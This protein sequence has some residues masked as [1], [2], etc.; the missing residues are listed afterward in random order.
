MRRMAHA[1]QQRDLDRAV[2]FALRRL[3][4][5]DGAVLIVRALHDQDRHADIGQL[6][7]DVPFAEIG[8]EPGVVPAAEG[9]VDVGVPARELRA[10]VGRRID[11]PRA[12]DLGDAHVF[13][14]EMRRNQNEPAHAM[15]LHRAGIDRRDRSAVAVA[16]QQPAPEAD[17]VEQPRQH[18]VRLVVH[19]GER[20]RQRSPATT[21]RSRRANRRTRRRRSRPRACPE[22]RPTARRSRAPRAASRW[23]APASGRGPIMRYSSRISAPSSRKPWSASVMAG[24]T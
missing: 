8:I 1:R 6:G 22:N 23:S 20:T 5:P 9:V 19:E 18:V 17:R 15:V 11:V 4:L 10:Q 16:E 24:V 7:G 2:A 21:G 13:G 14:E 12:R 3:D